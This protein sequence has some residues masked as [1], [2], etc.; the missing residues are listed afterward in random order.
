MGLLD[1]TA[2]MPRRTMVLFFVVDVSSSMHG[3][4]IGALNQAIKEILPMVDEISSNNAD[5]EIKI[6]CLQFSSGCNWMFTAP[7]QAS[8]FVWQDL[9]ANGLTSLGEA[10]IELGS[11][12]S[13][14]EFLENTEGS[15]APA[16]ILLSDGGPTDDFSGGLRKLKENKWFKASIKVAVAIGKDANKDVLKDFTG[17]IESVIEVHNVDALK[18][19]IRTVT[20]TASQIG[21]KSSTAANK[22]KQEQVNNVVKKVASETPGAGSAA[23][24]DSSIDNNDDSDWD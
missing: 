4:K 3:T 18:T 1:E 20:I 10:C 11:K 2:P 8:E 6:A 16:L 13:R 7:K 5:A 21:S 9:V 12:L 24:P 23:N 17:N 22:S 14:S 15:F 19:I